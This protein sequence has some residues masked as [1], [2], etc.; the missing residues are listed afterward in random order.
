MKFILTLL[1]ML[2]GIV[3]GFV[4]CIALLNAPYQLLNINF[5]FADSGPFVVASFVA[6]ALLLW[7]GWRLL[8]G[9]RVQ[10]AAV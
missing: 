8:R 1:R 7:G 5:R 4:G 2:A 10:P 9:R 6:G 3:I